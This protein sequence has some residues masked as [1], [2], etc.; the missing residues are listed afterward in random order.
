MSEEMELSAMD[1]V[2]G[3]VD[4]DA[5]AAKSAFDALVTARIGEKIEEIRPDVAASLFG[6]DDAED[7]DDDHQI[8]DD[9][10]DHED[11][12][13]EDEDDDQLQAD[14]E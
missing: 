11:S 8:T 9:E 7:E 5:L 13:E 6:P 14:E 12:E 3:I 1:V 10:D 4:G 2:R